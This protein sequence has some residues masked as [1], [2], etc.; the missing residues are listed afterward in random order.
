MLYNVLTSVSYIIVK[1]KLSTFGA[2]K[3]T[4]VAKKCLV[5]ISL[6]YSIIYSISTHYSTHTHNCTCEKPVERNF[7]F[8]RVLRQRRVELTKS[9]MKP[10]I[11]CF[12][13]LAR[14]NVH[15]YSFWLLLSFVNFYSHTNVLDHFAFR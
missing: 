9:N 12:C 10:C 11:W 14:I 1:D 5:V 15:Y 2:W 4:Q 7:Y 8:V 6:Y 13:F 3:Y